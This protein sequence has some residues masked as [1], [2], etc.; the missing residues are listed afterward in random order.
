MNRRTFF[1]RG[2]KAAAGLAAAAA[3]AAIP[4]NV[5]APEELIAVV[6]EVQFDLVPGELIT[7][8]YSAQVPITQELL[9]D[10]IDPEV[11][12]AAIRRA[13]Q[14]GWERSWLTG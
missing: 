2:A 8:R 14:H 7:Y 10:V 3:L 11:F 1:S 6:D 13:L 9:D 12:E 4:E 5:E